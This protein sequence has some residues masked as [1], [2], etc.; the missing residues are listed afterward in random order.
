MGWIFFPKLILWFHLSLSRASAWAGV[1][2]KEGAEQIVG[3]RQYSLLHHPSVLITVT[4]S[5]IL[6][7]AECWNSGSW[8]LRR[9]HWASSC[10][11]SPYNPNKEEQ[12]TL[13]LFSFLFLF[14]RCRFEVPWRHNCMFGDKWDFL[15]NHWWQRP[16]TQMRAAGSELV[17]WC[18]QMGFYINQ[19]LQEGWK[20]CRCDCQRGW[21]R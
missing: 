11:L 18:S 12:K 16:A 2:F 9:E 7:S 3:Q 5:N 15:E 1:I 6:S 8:W 21:T 14:L 17:V 20:N 10:S 19:F 4:S 13:R